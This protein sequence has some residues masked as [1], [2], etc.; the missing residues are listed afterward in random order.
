MFSMIA[1]YIP[2]VN[3]LFPPC[4]LLIYPQNLQT[5]LDNV[6]YVNNTEKFMAIY[7]VSFLNYSNYKKI[8][9][10]IAIKILLYSIQYENDKEHF[11]K[12]R[13]VLFLSLLKC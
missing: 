13:R 4:G 3:L 6:Y 1:L 9:I 12:M 7:N 8:V 11:Y 10:N 2:H 5:K